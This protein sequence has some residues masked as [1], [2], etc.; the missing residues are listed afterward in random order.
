MKEH[1]SLDTLPALCALSEAKGKRA[2][3][4]SFFLISDIQYLKC[5]NYIVYQI[6]FSPNPFLP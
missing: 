6:A 2:I 1:L 5:L 3:H 4:V